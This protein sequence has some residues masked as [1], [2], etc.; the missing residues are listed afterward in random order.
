MV[1]VILDFV[2]YVQGE[3]QAAS[4]PQRQAKN[5]DKGINFAAKNIT[6]RDGNVIAKHRYVFPLP[7]KKQCHALIK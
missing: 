5:I 3:Q 6:Q 1:L 2:L 7:Q 4:Y